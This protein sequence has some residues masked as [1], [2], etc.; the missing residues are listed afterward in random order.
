MIGE[1]LVRHVLPGDPTQESTKDL[2]R[3]FLVVDIIQM[4]S[5][6][7]SRTIVLSDY[8]LPEVLGRSGTRAIS[9]HT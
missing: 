4:Q 2:I 3:G 5:C 9:L 8:T 6:H 7:N 1:V